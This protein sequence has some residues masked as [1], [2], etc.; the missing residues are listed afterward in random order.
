MKIRQIL[1][2]AEDVYSLKMTDDILKLIKPEDIIEIEDNYEENSYDF[3]IYRMIEETEEQ[4]KE[5]N[6]RNDK[7][8][9]L[10]KAS[11]KLE[12]LRLKEEFEN[13]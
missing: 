9:A 5:R 11:R 3:Y 1:H 7:R 6:I 4:T 13:E 12:Y 10:S 8:N 2:T